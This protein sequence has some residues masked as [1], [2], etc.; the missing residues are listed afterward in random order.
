MPKNRVISHIV[1][2]AIANLASIVVLILFWS[3][4]QTTHKT[5]LLLLPVIAAIYLL[6]FV[7]YIELRENQFCLK[8]VFESRLY[9]YDN[10][11]SIE[12]KGSGESSYLK[13]KMTKP[14]YVR[15]VF[16]FHGITDQSKMIELLKSRIH[17]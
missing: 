11:T 16:T 2:I 13:V 10:I 3:N 4:I 8:T 12:I 17:K 6:M 9:G 5:L 1:L 14:L 15:K 7:Q